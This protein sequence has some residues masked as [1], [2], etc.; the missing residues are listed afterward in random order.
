MVQAKPNHKMLIAKRALSDAIAPK[1]A[2]D[3][4]GFNKQAS[5]ACCISH[6]C[7]A[8][9]YYINIYTYIDIY[10]KMRAYDGKIEFSK[11]GHKQK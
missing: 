3:I 5:H 6:M 4:R 7:C 2:K 8:H 11:T 10:F 1:H 9:T